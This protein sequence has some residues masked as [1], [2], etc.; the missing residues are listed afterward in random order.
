MATINSFR[1]RIKE[2]LTLKSSSELVLHAMRHCFQESGGE[3]KE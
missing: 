1:F 2:K 3:S